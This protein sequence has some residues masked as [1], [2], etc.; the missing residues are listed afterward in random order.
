MNAFVFAPAVR[1]N[2]HVLI[3]LAGA[4]GSGKTYSGLEL[5][6]GLAGERGKIAM[7][8]TEAGRGLHYADKFKF[9]HCELSPPFTPDR[10]REAIVAAAEA[11]ATVVLVDSMSH[12]HDG[13][14]GLIEMAAQEMLT[15]R[16][17]NSAAA[18]A[19]PK[20]KHKRMM[21]RL[22][23]L[24]VHLIFCLRAEE[25]V[26]MVKVFDERKQREITVVEP[27]GWQPICEKRFMFEMTA[28]FVLMPDNPG[29]PGQV[30]KLQEQHRAAFPE[31]KPISRESGRVIGEWASG[32]AAP[33]QQ[34]SDEFTDLDKRA[35]EAANLGLD[36][37]REFWRKLARDERDHLKPMSKKFEAMSKKADAER[38]P[39]DGQE[40][41]PEDDPPSTQTQG[42]VGNIPNN[43]PNERPRDTPKSLAVPMRK[44]SGGRT[45]WLGTKDDM[46][47][48]IGSI[49]DPRD[50]APTGAFMRDNRSNLETMRNGDKDAWSDVKRGLGN[51]ERVLNGGEP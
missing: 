41:H 27:A 1:R 50:V 21:N 4:S 47:E 36:N 30:L 24:R 12:E 31:G 39:F 43:T 23:Q 48:A 13:E 15:R 42:A 20:A 35:E 29:V 16:D 18:W 34:G 37:L 51:R 28:S 38:E 8:D 19:L 17:G 45:D 44:A 22:L 49:D 40:E 14:G 2:T 10:Y 9:D 25:K 11:G 33:E 46:L 7:L 5:A 26:K 6:T 32:A 3:A